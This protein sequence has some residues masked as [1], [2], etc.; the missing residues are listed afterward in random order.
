MKIISRIDLVS[1]LA[2]PF[3]LGATSL[4]AERTPFSDSGEIHALQPETRPADAQGTLQVDDSRAEEWKARRRCV[5]SL[6]L[7]WLQA[8]RPAI[9]P[10]QQT[11][12][13]YVSLGPAVFGALFKFGEEQPRNSHLLTGGGENQ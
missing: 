2:G 12:G 3:L 13:P 6:L 1:L 9:R 8:G 11:G 7:H 4:S 5:R 10:V